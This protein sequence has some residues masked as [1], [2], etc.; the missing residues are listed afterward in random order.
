LLKE[1]GDKRDTNYG[2]V[3]E[4]RTNAATYNTDTHGAFMTLMDEILFQRRVELWSEGMGRAF[5]LCRLNLG[6]DQIFCCREW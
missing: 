4:A 5:D 3:L 1:L 2:T 6:Y